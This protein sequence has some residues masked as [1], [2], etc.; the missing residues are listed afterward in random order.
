MPASN[1]SPLTRVAYWAEARQQ[2]EAQYR[3]AVQ[4][5]AREGHGQSRIASVAGVTRQAIHEQ[6][7]KQGGKP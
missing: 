4:D 5:A 6:L 1:L 2:A 7:R 3:Q